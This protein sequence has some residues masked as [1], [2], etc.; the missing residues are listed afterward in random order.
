MFESSPIVFYAS[1]VRNYVYITVTC[2]CNIKAFFFNILQWMIFFLRRQFYFKN[3]MGIYY[4]PILAL[5][6]KQWKYILTF[7]LLKQVF[8]LH[9]I[10]CLFFQGARDIIKLDFQKSGHLRKEGRLERSLLGQI[11][12]V[13][14]MHI[15]F[16][17]IWSN[18]ISCI[19]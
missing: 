2:T 5:F 16:C 3:Q 13:T 18:T 11:V 14:C 6:V 10:I 8:F 7:W 9:C 12:G 19:I 4:F 15:V 17:W 1:F